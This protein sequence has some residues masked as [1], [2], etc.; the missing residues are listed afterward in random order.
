VTAAGKFEWAVITVQLST[1]V[2]IIKGLQLKGEIKQSS[3]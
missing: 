1:A 2:A 3:A